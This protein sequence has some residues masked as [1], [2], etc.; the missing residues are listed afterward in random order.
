MVDEYMRTSD[1]NI[2]AAGDA[3]QIKDYQSGQDALVPLAGPANRQ[4]WIIANNIAGRE[5]K[6]PGSQG[7][8]FDVETFQFLGGVTLRF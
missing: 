7:T 6:Y 2:Y 4:G 1:P 3:V 5:L 8:E